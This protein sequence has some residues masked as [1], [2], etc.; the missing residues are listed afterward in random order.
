MGK[1]AVE[2]KLYCHNEHPLDELPGLSHEDRQPC[3]VCG[4]KSRLTK[5]GIDS[6]FRPEGHLSYRHRSPGTGRWLTE[7]VEGASFYKATGVW[8]T[9]SRLIDRIAGRYKERVVNE[10]GEVI[11]EIDDPLSEHRGRGSAK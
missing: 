1:T 9:L 10:K 8:H 2:P 4:S 11:R 5:V 7:R 3:P 6:S